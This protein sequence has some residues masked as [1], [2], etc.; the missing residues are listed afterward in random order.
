[1]SMLVPYDVINIYEECLEEDFLG[2]HQVIKPI[3]TS[4][5]LLCTTVK[6][7]QFQIVIALLDD[8]AHM[9]FSSSENEM[10]VTPSLRPRKT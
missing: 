2:G 7:K 9:N 6:S 8:V 1:M 5:N 3:G 4:S 10:L